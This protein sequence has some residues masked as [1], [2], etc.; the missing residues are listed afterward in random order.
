M[1]VCVCLFVCL[2]VR[3]F[4]CLFV[5]LFVVSG[6]RGF[7]KKRREAYSHVKRLPNIQYTYAKDFFIGENL[8]PSFWH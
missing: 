6:E 4:V 7:K 1:F 5:C 3:S 2:F 8:N